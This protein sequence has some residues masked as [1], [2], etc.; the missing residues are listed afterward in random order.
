MGE[1]IEINYPIY[2]LSK[3]RYDTNYT[4]KFLI[5]DNINFYL[6][7]EKEEYDLYKKALPN[8]NII[9]LPESN[10]GPCYVRNFIFQ[11]SINKGHKKHWQLDDNIRYIKRWHKG[12]RIRANSKLAFFTCEQISDRYEN[13]GLIGLNYSMF[14]ISKAPYYRTNVHV[15]SFFLIN[16][17]TPIRFRG[18]FNLDTDICL[19]YLTNK[20]ATIQVQAFLA[21]K[22]A[23]MTMKGG[24][25]TRYKGTG[26]LKMAKELENNWPQF[27]KTKIRFNRHQH[28]V[29]W[30]KF[31][32]LK[33]IKKTNYNEIVENTKTYD[34]KL[35]VKKT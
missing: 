1:K 19:Q 5:N 12:K 24:N 8:V 32:K 30:N 23:T 16:N 7:V 21:D 25:T 31:K 33:L 20:Y 34:I 11:D 2:V 4:A 9:Q 35:K 6:I 27:V 17:E 22:I 28:V 10:K 3:G 13:V 26:R 15:Y 14:G 18:Q 29:S